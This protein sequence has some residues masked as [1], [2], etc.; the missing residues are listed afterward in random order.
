[1]PPLAGRLKLINFPIPASNK[2]ILGT[3][4]LENMWN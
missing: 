4:F 1:M 2:E 3:I